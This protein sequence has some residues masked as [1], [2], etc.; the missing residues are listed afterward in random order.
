[1]ATRCGGVN[2]KLTTRCS[3]LHYSA[4]SKVVFERDVDV[5][6]PKLYESVS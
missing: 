4:F 6:A 2:G 5:V 1:M 3:F